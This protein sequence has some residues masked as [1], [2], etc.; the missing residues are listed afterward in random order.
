MLHNLDLF[1]F[2]FFLSF[3]PPSLPSTYVAFTL[4]TWYDH[5]FLIL[6]RLNLKNIFVQCFLSAKS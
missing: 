6:I 3:Q 1:F 4:T 2:G 5:S